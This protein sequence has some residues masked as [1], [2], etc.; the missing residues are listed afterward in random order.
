MVGAPVGAVTVPDIRELVEVVERLDGRIAWA[1]E[2]KL[3]LIELPMAE[4]KGLREEFA[5][6]AARVDEAE[7]ARKRV[8]SDE[9]G[10]GAEELYWLR[11]KLNASITHLRDIEDYYRLLGGSPEG[12]N[13]VRADRARQ[14]YEAI[15][16]DFVNGKMT[17]RTRAEAEARV[18]ELTEAL[19][20]AS[21]LLD[22]EGYFDDPDYHAE[23]SVIQ[24]ALRGAVLV[25]ES[26]G[27]PV[28]D[29]TPR[30]PEREVVAIRTVPPHDH[31][32]EVK[33][34]DGTT[35]EA[36]ALAASI[37][38]HE[39]HYIMRR[40][41]LPLPILLHVRQCPDCLERVVWA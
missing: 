37:E 2:H 26:G 22:G 14:L 36:S 12:F 41:D 25:R 9:G 21:R 13:M 32:S 29:N 27:Q 1:R 39:A 28:T 4:A 40:H 11:A 8:P 10:P 18:E 5:A 3:T 31:I 7:R 20:L 30:V 17:R 19:R 33:L 38:A 6:L 34:A 24:E 23:I 16:E 15:T 35:V